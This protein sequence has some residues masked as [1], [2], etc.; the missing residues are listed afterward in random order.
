MRVLVTGG[1]G[2]IGSCK[3]V[4]RQLGGHLDE[5]NIYLKMMFVELIG[6]RVEDE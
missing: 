1:A 4:D 3:L 2:Y 5:R 6:W